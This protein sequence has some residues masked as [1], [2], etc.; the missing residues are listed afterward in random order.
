MGYMPSKAGEFKREGGKVRISVQGFDFVVTLGLANVKERDFIM[1]DVR[2]EVKVER[3]EQDEDWKGK[4]KQI[5][6]RFG[7]AFR[8]HVNDQAVGVLDSMVDK[9]T[10]IV[11]DDYFLVKA[12]YFAKKALVSVM[13]EQVSEEVVGIIKR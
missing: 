12:V 3:N 13:L 6:E 5:A 2:L 8:D 11:C 7:A 1:P 9:E 10:G 4:E